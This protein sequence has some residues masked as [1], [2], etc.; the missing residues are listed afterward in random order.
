MGEP[1]ELHVDPPKRLCPR[2]D[3]DVRRQEVQDDLLE[4]ARARAW[5]Y[6]WLAFPRA[7]FCAWC[8]VNG[9]I[10]AKDNREG[11]RAGGPTR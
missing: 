9:G 4:Q 2:P 1:V 10:R 7:A 8:K 11:D 5:L 3:Q 6:W